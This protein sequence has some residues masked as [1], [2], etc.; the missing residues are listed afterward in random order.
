MATALS[1]VFG[2]VFSMIH[3]LRSPVGHALK[4]SW[5]P[6]TEWMLRILKIGSP[7][8]V[9]NLLRSV[10][11]WA[12]IGILGRITHATEAQAALFIG[13]QLEGLAFMPGFGFNIAAATLVGQNLGARKVER[14]EKSAWGSVAF[15]SSMMAAIA[16]VFFIFA[17]P[18]ARLF[19]KDPMVVHYAVLYLRINAISEPFLGLS[20]V[21][22]GAFEGAG[23]TLPPTIMTLLSLWAFRLPIASILSIT[24]GYGVIGAWAAMSVSA[25][26][27]GLLIALMFKRG[28]WRHK[29]V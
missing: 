27:Q 24:L 18:L 1:Q 28:R 6:K 13:L 23:D 7:A 4:G 26:L 29:K 15:G 12:F 10:G 3:L 8:A 20:M 9:Q 21:L 22:T 2:M 5:K 16:L 19:T 14:A 25:I 17:E 11:S